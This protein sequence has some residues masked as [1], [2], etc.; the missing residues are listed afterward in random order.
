MTISL[1]IEIIKIF[2]LEFELSS[3]KEFKFKKEKPDE[4]E[5]A[6]TV[7]PNDKQPSKG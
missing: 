6:I 3:N 1:K 4:K 7:S 2:K 5:T